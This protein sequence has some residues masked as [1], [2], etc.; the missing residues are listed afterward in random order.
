MQAIKMTNLELLSEL[1]KEKNN[2]KKIVEILKEINFRIHLNKITFKGK[3][4]KYLYLYMLS[5]NKYGLLNTLNELLKNEE[6]IKSIDISGINGSTVLSLTDKCLKPRSCLL[7]NSENI[8]NSIIKS[9]LLFS[10]VDFL[11]ELTK[12]E[13]LIL[14]EDIDID[15][16]LITNGIRFD[17]LR[18]ETE[19]FILDDVAIFENYNIDTI[20]EFA[21][22]YSDLKTL[23]HN[24]EFIK[25]YFE[26]IDDKFNQ[27][28][29]V[30]Y[31]LTSKQVKD[32]KSV[33]TDNGYL[34]LVKDSQPDIQKLLLQ[35]KKIEKLLVNCNDINVLET[36]PKEYL[37][38]LLTEK[39][40][41][42]SG[43]NLRM[44]KNLNKK[45]LSKV[46]Q[47]NK[48]FYSD[49]I[50]RIGI[51]ENLDFKPFISALPTELLHDLS[52]KHLSSFNF[53]VLK[54]LLD[55]NKNFFK[56]S[57]LCNEKVSNYLVNRENTKELLELL[58][59]ADF[60]NEEKIRLLLNSK[61]IKNVNNLCEI[62]YTIP[63]NLRLPI[64]KEEYLRDLILNFEDY[65]LDS[66][67]T[68]YLLDNPNE[69]LNI[70]IKII[71]GLLNIADNKFAEELL[72]SEEILD[73]V[74][75]EG[76]TKLPDK[77][78]LLLKGKPKLLP[79]YKKE[80]V[81]KYYSKEFL[82]AL[83]DVIDQNEMNNICS[84]EI[85][86]NIYQNNELINV[87]KKLLNNNSYLLNTLDFNII[88][89]KTKDLKL[90]ILDKI[91]K[92]P[93]IEKDLVE[94]LDELPLPGE[95]I[96]QLYFGT[97]E[98]NF[99]ETVY[100]ILEVIRLSIEGSNR[101][102][103]GNIGKMIKVSSPN[104][105]SKNNFNKLI[106]YILYFVP[107]YNNLKNSIIKTPSTFNEIIKYE[108]EVNKKLTELIAK[109]INIRENFL[110]KHFKLT[111]EESLAIISKY[112]IDRIDSNI[113][114]EEYSFLDN[115]NKI[116]NTDE[117]SIQQMDS[118]YKTITMF[119]S[120]A[121][122]EKIKK[123]Y[124]KIYNF[125]IRSKTYANKPTLI[126]V[127]GKE[128]KVYKC[129]S[130][131][132]FLISNLDIS[133]EY[134]K[135]NSFLLGWHNTINKQNGIHVSLIANDNLH[136][137][138]DI[139]FGFNGVLEEGIKEISPYYS[140]KTKYMTPREL[141]D[142][143]RD[144]NNRII[145]DQ[146]A[147]R[148]SFN[149]SNLPNIEPDYI[150]VDANRLDDKNYLE[151][152]SR[153][154]FEFRT[155]RN[156]EGLP[157]IAIDMEKIANSETKKID[158]IFSKYQRTHDMTLLN[159]IITK[160]NNNYTAYHNYNNELAAKFDL[161]I[162]I[163]AVKDRVLNSNSISEIEYIENV[164]YE[165]E[166]KYKYLVKEYNYEEDVKELKRTIDKR[167]EELNK[168]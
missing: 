108:D 128:L 92:Y 146:Y 87:Y 24:K 1:E 75:S 103:V 152:I 50:E 96:N 118:K 91:T 80:S 116:F 157:I 38:N 167:L 150:L 148:P 141:I 109:G 37:I 8:K 12:E 142:N 70:P 41:I 119:D 20:R 101:K 140:K 137:P 102:R 117:E 45:E 19:K 133:E 125:E 156:K 56:D 63:E 129:P 34:H 79:Y 61:D 139:T 88:N 5:S 47:K 35:Q 68:R 6:F 29:K 138:K 123:M 60:N 49:L 73:K 85:I 120:F 15:N 149:N 164:F 76:S 145:L 98:L 99:E 21:N 89:D 36:L 13:M 10:T 17:S 58:E 155:K 134:K 57:I 33:I 46:V 106:N 143:T 77:L 147:I 82:T 124:G 7:R 54:K 2:S 121:I 69:T 144:I 132:M 59:D 90:M 27:A 42:L 130:D 52:I 151:K 113:Y 153:A 71:I 81:H 48:H 136:L 22:N 86:K 23:A 154:S 51:D 18:S 78:A 168:G 166:N 53:E 83:R 94:I 65:K 126:N 66:Y 131:F 25:I 30:F 16:Y 9:D 162:I 84:N 111:S 93:N 4:N 110:L 95:F 112:S 104:G 55:S 163:K 14:R 127:F 122:E 43:I 74:F 3:E 100:N 40:N 114:K 165:E 159:S 115:L 26:K 11:D 97:Q 72:A 107:R 158:T 161:S 160:I 105:L 67:T 44:L 62:V 135:T 32:L 31:Y 64:Y 39:E 28:N